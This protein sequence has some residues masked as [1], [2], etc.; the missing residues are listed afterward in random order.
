MSKKGSGAYTVSDKEGL[1]EMAA[2]RKR[3]ARPEPR[4]RDISSDVDAN[5]GDNA[6]GSKPIRKG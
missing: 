2:M 6:Q 1:A 4:S 5:S 3:S